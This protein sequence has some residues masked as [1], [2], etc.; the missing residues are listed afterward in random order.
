MVHRRIQRV[1]SLALVCFVVGCAGDG[2]SVAPVKRE[3]PSKQ[4]QSARTALRDPGSAASTV[5]RFWRYVGAGAM[6]AAFLLY[7]EDVTRAL[8]PGEFGG[9]MVTQ[10]R[11]VAALR[12]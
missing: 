6:P 2:G 5:M 11:N 9:M 1:T 3:K 7:S 12:T 4:S 10:Q 8:G